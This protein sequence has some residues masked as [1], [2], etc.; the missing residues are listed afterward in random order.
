VDDDS[1]T[2][3]F[4]T[5]PYLSGKGLQLKYAFFGQVFLK[6]HCTE[7]LKLIGY[8]IWM[9]LSTCVHVDQKEVAVSGLKMATL[10]FL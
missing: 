5:F 8:L 9:T 7:I 2:D 10:L 1:E 3:G 6:I 4:I